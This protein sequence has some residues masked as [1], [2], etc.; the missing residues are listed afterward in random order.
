[1]AEGKIDLD[2]D[3][4]V[5]REEIQLI[6]FSFTDRGGITI[7]KKDDLKSSLG[8]SPDRLDAVIMAACDMSPWTGNPYN[9]MTPG[10]AVAVD[11]EEMPWFSESLPMVGPGLP[12]L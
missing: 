7:T 6:T 12:L 11:R 8:G 2:Y 5:L 10:E 9:S 3:D 4:D 1:M